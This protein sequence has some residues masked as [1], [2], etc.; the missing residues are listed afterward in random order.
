MTVRASRALIVSTALCAATVCA[1]V[2]LQGAGGVSRQQ[3]DVFEKKLETIERNA[4]A[5]ASRAPARTPVTETEINSWFTYRSEPVL[6]DGLTKP[7]LTIVGNGQVS[8]TATLDLDA[9]AKSRQS[10]RTFDVWNLVGGQMPVTVAGVVRTR[11]GKGRFELQEASVAGIP[12]P[13]RV[14]QELL[15]YYSRS[16]R[17]PNGRRLEDE[18]EL[19]AGIQMI[20]TSPG[21]AV[22]VQ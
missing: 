5:K 19:P 7:S 11:G 17:H 21:A 2:S 14:V 3:A 13:R 10:G 1:A 20:E 12:V 6:P 15:S 16:P 8:G 4:A 22:V 9:V 18:F